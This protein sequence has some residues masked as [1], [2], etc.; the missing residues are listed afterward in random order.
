MTLQKP[1]TFNW[2]GVEQIGWHFSTRL[3]P[4]IKHQQ[5][6]TAQLLQVHGDKIVR[7]NQALTKPVEADAVW[8]DDQTVCAIRTADCVP[9]LW[10]NAQGSRVGAIHAGW[11]GLAK[12]IIT[13]M[14]DQLP[15]DPSSLKVWMGPHIGPH[16]F[17]VRE[18][19]KK[20]FPTMADA[21]TSIG[22][23]QWQCNLSMIA[24]RQLK[25]A[26]IQ[27]Q[28]ITL[29]PYCTF[30]NKKTLFS[31]RRDPSTTARHISQIWRKI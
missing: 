18:D 15:D 5:R 16:A 25:E 31:Y 29:Q 9:I 28:Q 8:S 23:G 17:V 11:R 24:M 3:T 4:P 12:R 26:G 19:M 20:N 27:T 2:P 1:L 22:Q 6:P 7:A 13:K 30:T 10:T 21:F 14:F